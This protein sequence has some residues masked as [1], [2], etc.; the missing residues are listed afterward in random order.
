MFPGICVYRRADPAIERHERYGACA[1]CGGRRTVMAGW[2]Q[3]PCDRDP[4]VPCISDTTNA[5]SAA[6]GRGWPISAASSTTVGG[7]ILDAD[8]RPGA[9]GVCRASQGKGCAVPATELL[10]LLLGWPGY[11]R[12]GALG[13]DQAGQGRESLAGIA[14]G[15]REEQ[16]AEGRPRV[17][18]DGLDPPFQCRGGHAGAAGHVRVMGGPAPHGSRLPVRKKCHL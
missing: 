16:S 6:M 17:S 4:S 7:P 11:G 13:R 18:G 5:S 12:T 14:G 1:G 15:A 10:L 3:I 8:R 2:H 9:C